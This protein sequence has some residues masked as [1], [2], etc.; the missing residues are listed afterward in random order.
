MNFK[1]IEGRVESS[2]RDPAGFVFSRNGILYRQINK[3]YRHQYNYLLSSGLYEVLAKQEL[4][5]RHK[6]VDIDPFHPNSSH[7]IIKPYTLPF[8]SYPYE[9]CFNQLK[10]AALCTLEILEHSIK[11]SMILKDC[12]AY[13]IQFFK[14]K[15]VFIDT[16]SFDSYK[17][18][19]PWVGYRQFCQHFLAPLLLMSHK[20]PRMVQLLQSNVD[21]I[22]VDLTSKLLPF[23]TW[24]SPSI[25]LHIHLH[26]KLQMRYRTQKPSKQKKALPTRSLSGMIAHL[27]G[28]I[29]KMPSPPAN[30]TWIEYYSHFSY[31]QSSFS[32]KKEVISNYLDQTKPATLWDL[33]CNDGT[34][35][36]LA[37]DKGILVTA[38]DSDHSVIDKNHTLNKAKNIRGVLPLVAELTNPSPPSGWANK[39][40]K[41][42]E[43]RGPADCMLALALVHHIAIGNNVPFE[44]I[45]QYFS[46]LCKVLIIEFVPVSDP[47]VKQLLCTRFDSF[48]WYSQP[49]FEHSFMQHFKIGNI[50]QLRESLRTLYLMERI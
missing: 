27:K 7:L 28:I 8:I 16:L 35:S 29:S 43:Q 2:F 47:Q 44:M 34:F 22:P 6:Q 46:K 32:E 33:G 31:S 3:Q 42:L 17:A 25:F 50:Y 37:Q 24:L 1:M 20:D 23:S 48:E 15:A 21:G 18:G 41:S 40:H 13:N 5:I 4:L 10:D 36:R 38:F 19:D 9:W 49:N 26:A 11:H 45:A 30:K 14:G 39:E 12:S